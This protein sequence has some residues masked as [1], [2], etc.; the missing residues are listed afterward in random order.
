MFQITDLYYNFWKRD[1]K[2]FSGIFAETVT[3]KEA[4]WLEDYRETFSFYAFTIVLS[5]K[6]KIK[7]DGE[8]ISLTKDILHLYLPGSEFALIEVSTDYKAICVISD[9]GYL[10]DLPCMERLLALT[11]SPE[12]LKLKGCLQLTEEEYIRMTKLF[13]LLEYYS[14]CSLEYKSNC[15]K[16]A[17]SILIYDLSGILEINKKEKIV[18]ENLERIFFKFFQLLKENFRTQHEIKFYSDK[19]GIT[20]EY[21]SRIVR[22]I[23][24]KTIIHFINRMLITEAAWQLIHTEL[25]MADLATYLNFAT[26]ASLSKFFKSH[27]GFSPLKYRLLHKNFRSNKST[28]NYIKT[29]P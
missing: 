2:N 9:E 27:K 20:P 22:K 16:E 25:S 11:Y 4:A 8:N 29:F 7:Y 19:L 26:S 28:C 18:S 17:F 21:L 3:P 13:T 14:A 23:T 5:G 15:I 6:I 24:G 10:M 1:F 12:L